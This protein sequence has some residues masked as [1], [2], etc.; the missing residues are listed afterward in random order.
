MLTG[1]S[2][3]IWSMI[4]MAAQPSMALCTSPGYMEGNRASSLLARLL[5][6][7]ALVSGWCAWDGLRSWPQAGKITMRGGD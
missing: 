6:V 4:G 7:V 1:S 2:V 3:L 5:F